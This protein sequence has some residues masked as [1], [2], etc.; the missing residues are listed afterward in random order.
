MGTRKQRVLPEIQNQYLARAAHRLVAFDQFSWFLHFIL[1]KDCSNKCIEDKCDDSFV[2]MLQPWSWP[3]ATS[4]AQDMTLS[5]ARSCSKSGVRRP[6]GF[7]P[8][9]P[10]P[11]MH[12][13]T[14]KM[15]SEIEN[16]WAPID[17][18]ETA[19]NGVNLDVSSETYQ[20]K[21]AQASN[22]Q[23]TCF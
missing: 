9:I 5:V 4:W 18:L 3:R 11:Q 14:L 19:L 20:K 17:F 13:G 15:R 22:T 8:E 2:L 10:A 16:L 7:A 23:I 6:G 12:H 1:R 21:A